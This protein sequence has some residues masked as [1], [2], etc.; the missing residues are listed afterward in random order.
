ME[1]Y[2]KDNSNI[3]NKIQEKSKSF[4]FIN[5]LNF[6]NVSHINIISLFLYDEASGIKHFNKLSNK[7]LIKPSNEKIQ[8]LHN[9]SDEIKAQNICSNNKE[10]LIEIKVE[11]SEKLFR[12]ISSGKK[13]NN[14]LIEF[15]KNII[16]K[17]KNRECISCRKIAS[18]YEKTFKRKIGK[19]TIHIILK[20]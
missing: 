14:E 11:Y 19:S 4:S 17:N 7:N 6:P 20:S 12:Q 10:A 3:L 8:L 16:E 9:I 18:M 13:V 5:S 2:P 1:K 15:A